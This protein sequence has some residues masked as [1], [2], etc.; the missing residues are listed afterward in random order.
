MKLTFD[1]AKREQT[2]RDRGIDFLDAILLFE[3]LT[4]TFEDRRFDYGETRYLSF[5][6]IEERLMCV[7]WTPRGEARHIISMRKCNEREIAKYTPF[8]E[9]MGQG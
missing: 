8:L 4:V 7:V 5:G 1:P 3:S 9:R 2:L 6:H